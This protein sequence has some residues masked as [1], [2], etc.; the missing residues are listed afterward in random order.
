MNLGYPAE[1]D[2]LDSDIEDDP[3]QGDGDMIDIGE[4]ITYN[5][6]LIIKYWL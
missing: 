5:E 3:H 1:P 4:L 6:D 2:I